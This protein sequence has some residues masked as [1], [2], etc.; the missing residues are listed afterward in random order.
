MERCFMKIDIIGSVASGKTTLAKNISQSY[1]V[2]YFEKDNIVWKRTPNGD[3]KR[4][5]QERDI[6]FHSIISQ[7]DW[8]VEGSPRE[9]L[10]ESFECCDYIIVLDIPIFIRLK[11][12]FS[13]WIRQR[14]GKE[15][16]NSKPTWIFLCYNI[17]WVFEFNKIRTY[18]LDELKKY[19][20][21]IVVLK[22]NKK[23]YDFI[24]QQ[25]LISEYTSRNK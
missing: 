25:F 2:P 14:I 15:N 19:N 24:T 9:C 5:E 3:V 11:R 6:L 10:K 22:N 8:I 7:S 23:A 1:N 12:V 20:T 13:R 17:K 21:Q 4:T 18:L 16:Y